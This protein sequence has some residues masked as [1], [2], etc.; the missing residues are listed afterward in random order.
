MNDTL[1]AIKRTGARLCLDCG[2]CT[3]VC[4][5]SRVNGSFSPRRIVT[6]ALL[7]DE[8]AMTDDA[9]WQCLTCKLCSERCPSD[10]D[11]VDL[12]KVVRITAHGGGKEATC[13]HGTAFQLIMKIMQ[14]PELKQN[15]MGWLTDGLKISDKSEYLY[16]VGCIPYFDA[17]FEDLKV[18]TSEIARSTV[19]ILN[20]L[21]IEPIVLRDERCCGH[22]LLWGGD[23]KNFKALVEHNVERLKATGA[24]KIVTACPECAVTLKLYYPGFAGALPFEVVHLSELLDKS[25]SSGALKLKK[26]GRRV[27]FQ[28]PCRLGRFLNV[29]EQPRS[30]LRALYGEGFGDMRRSRNA[31]IC[32]GTSGWMN[33]GL[34][35]KAIQTQRLKE[36]RTLG[37]DVLATACAK[38]KIHFMC[39]MKDS[40]FPEDAKIQ[41]EDLAVLV[42][43][44][45]DK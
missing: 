24:K 15:R 38:C 8:E 16:F 14:T 22:D 41:V 44:S 20:A 30:L 29:Y 35:S 12:T 31:A 9:I 34:H 28:D 10:V 21:G 19:K 27:T 17:F 6:D 43:S 39:A 32:C 40:G 2:K 11:Y 37:A 1:E 42:A 23:V 26:N 45:L 33:C 13:A 18:N 25:L 36:A 4:P 3:A 7:G 5:V